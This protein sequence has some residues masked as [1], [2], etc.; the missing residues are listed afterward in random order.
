MTEGLICCNCISTLH[1]KNTRKLF[2]KH[3]FGTW[4]LVLQSF[5]KLL[6]YCYLQLLLLLI[7]H[8]YL[9]KSL[10]LKAWSNWDKLIY[11]FSNSFI[12]ICESWILTIWLSWHQHSSQ[13]PCLL[14]YLQ[15]E[16]NL[17]SQ[18]ILSCH[19]WVW[20]I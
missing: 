10:A 2:T 1:F 12:F 3:N 20:K 8:F 13:S 9:D 7:F 17:D 19:K 5:P 14:L 16:I 11:N 4:N 18:K 15:E 6:L